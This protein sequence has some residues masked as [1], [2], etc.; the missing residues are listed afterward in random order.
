VSKQDGRIP[1]D[2]ADERLE[3]LVNTLAHELRTPLTVIIGYAELLLARDDEETR[4]SAPRAIHEAALALLARL[5]EL[6]SDGSASARTL[7]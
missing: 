6:T 7:D 4:R 2:A 1:P 3:R 5:D